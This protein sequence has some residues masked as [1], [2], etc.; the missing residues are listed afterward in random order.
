LAILGG[1]RTNWLRLVKGLNVLTY[2][3]TGTVLIA[4][5]IVWHRRD[6]E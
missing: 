2:A 1:A 5:D 6:K 4:V 3:D